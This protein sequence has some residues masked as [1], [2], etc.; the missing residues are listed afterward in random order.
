MAADGEA[1]SIGHDIALAVNVDQGRIEDFLRLASRSSTPLLTGDVTVKASLHIPPGPV[2]VHERLK[3]EGRFALENARFSSEKIQ[4]RI[5]DLSLRGQ[6]RTGELKSVD[7]ASILSR[8]Q[9]SF[10]MAGGVVTLPALI[11]IVPGAAIQLKGT[12]GIEG[13]ALHFDGSARM[14]AS[15]SKMVGGWKGLLLTP[16]ERRR[17]DRASH[18]HRGNA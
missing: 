7:P 17:G 18:S 5:M 10:Q 15:V 16:A 8:M 6:G 1:R 12:Y 11:Y 3:L 4:G 13:G 14:D 2:P 9:G